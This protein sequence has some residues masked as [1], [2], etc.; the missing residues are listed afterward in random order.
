MGGA[1]LGG[2]I[3]HFRHKSRERKMEKKTKT[4]L[5]KRDQQIESLNFERQQLKTEQLEQARKAEA[6]RYA[7]KIAANQE[8]AAT[9]QAQM[10]EVAAVKRAKELKLTAEQQEREKAALIDRLNAQATEQEQLAAEQL[11]AN[12][13]RIETSAWHSIEVDKH[14]HAVQETNIVYG[15][16]YYRERG[17]ETGPKDTATRS[18]ATGATALTGLAGGSA[19]DDQTNH[20]NTLGVSPVDGGMSDGG[21]N[22]RSAPAGIDSQP[23]AS[24]AALVPWIVILVAVSIVAIIVLW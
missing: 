19:A 7:N 3:E 17:H 11:A 16:E 24:F 8:L 10:S 22:G 5:K 21:T 23:P 1:I 9:A 6:E 18:S 13:N 20:A 2:L 14:G 15:H 12:E 4:E